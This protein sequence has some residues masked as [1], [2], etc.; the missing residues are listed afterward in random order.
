MPTT[1]QLLGLFEP[2][3]MQ[4]EADRGEDLGGEPSLAEMTR[5]AIEHLDND[6]GFFLMVEAG[7][8]DHAHHAGNAYRAL[9][10][11]V[12]YADAV[13]AA[14]AAT[15]PAETLIVVTADHSHTLTIAGYPGRGN[16]ILGYVAVNGQAQKDMAGND[17]TTLGY[18]NGPGAT[19]Q[20]ATARGEL[21]PDNIEYRQ[22]ATVPMPAETHAGDDVPAYAHGVGAE[23]IRGVMDQNE[24]YDVLANAL[25]GEDI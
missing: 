6:K 10:D 12:A 4:W 2:S 5:R 23:G 17:Y 15:D 19:E 20:A 3:H 25:F 22:N 24:I 8:I 7:R 1:G 9:V 16:P 21:E 11:T 13:A 14:V 18:A